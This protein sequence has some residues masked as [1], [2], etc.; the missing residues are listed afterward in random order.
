MNCLAG[1][2]F[3]KND[4]YA[5]FWIEDFSDEIKQSLRNQLSEICYGVDQVNSGFITYNYSNTV[6]EF[7]ERYKDKTPKTQKGMLGELL[8]HLIIKNYFDE[9]NSVTPFFNLEERSIKKGFDGVFTETG[10][11]VIWIVEVKSGEL[12]SNNTS[13]QTMSSLIG[14][15]K[16]DLYGRLNKK[17]IPLWLEA[18]YGAKV[19]YDSSDIMKTAIIKTLGNWSDNSTLGKHT[20][21]DKNVILTGVLFSD[22]SDSITETNLQLKQMNIEATKEFNQ[23]FVLGIQ[24][25]TYIKIYEFLKDEAKK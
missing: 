20:S 8:V 18:I 9:Y 24:K 21:K 12:H 11:A 25:E 13:D 2:N 16:S 4:N 14:T 23:V 6:K 10:K 1:V 22:L 15:A 3:I 19:A 17:N 7:L 5:V